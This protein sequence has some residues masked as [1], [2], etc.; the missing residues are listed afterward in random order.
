MNYTLFKL[1]EEEMY[2]TVRILEFSNYHLMGFMKQEVLAKIHGR[3]K[4]NFSWILKNFSTGSC[5]HNRPF[6]PSV[7]Y[8]LCHWAIG[9]RSVTIFKLLFRG[10]HLAER[11]KVACE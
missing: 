6:G 2:S 5:E 4:N 9:P 7:S 8:C 3:H 1:F 10:E 11:S